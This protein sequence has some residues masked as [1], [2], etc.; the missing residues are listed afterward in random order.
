MH[1]LE[2][3]ITPLTEEAKRLFEAEVMLVD[4]MIGVFI[5]DVGGGMFE[6][7]I[8]GIGNGTVWL[9]LELLVEK[10]MESD[11]ER[12]AIAL[13]AALTKIRDKQKS[14]LMN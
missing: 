2:V 11:P 10:M 14:G 4:S 12:T 6:K 3:K 13:E 9:G 7:N 5:T 1:N 8:K